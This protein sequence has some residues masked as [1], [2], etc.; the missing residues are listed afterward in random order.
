MEATAAGRPQQR[1]F[2]IQTWPHTPN[3]LTAA[4]ARRRKDRARVAG[5]LE[6]IAGRVGICVTLPFLSQFTGTFFQ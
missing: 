5:Q 6:N 3:K 1:P 4:V 2:A